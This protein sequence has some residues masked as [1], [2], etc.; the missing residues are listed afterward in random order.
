MIQKNPWPRRRTDFSRPRT[1]MLK[2]K[3]TRRRCSPKRKKKVFARGNANFQGKKKLMAMA[4][5]ERF[6]VLG[7]KQGIFDGLQASRPRIWPSRPK[8]RASKCVLEDSASVIWDS[9]RRFSTQKLF[10]KCGF[11]QDHLTVIRVLFFLISKKIFAIFA[12]M[13]SKQVGF[14]KISFVRYIAD[15]QTYSVKYAIPGTGA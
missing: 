7:R 9:Y 14:L 3:D 5:F 15:T 6:N 10:S 8:P 2:A 11:F 12:R 1:G 4:H 13:Y